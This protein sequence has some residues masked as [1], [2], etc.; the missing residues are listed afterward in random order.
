MT[1]WQDFFNDKSV[2][3]VAKLFVSQ[4]YQPFFDK[5]L[6]DFCR[7]SALAHGYSGHIYEF[8]P[9]GAKSIF[10]SGT[11]YPWGLAFNL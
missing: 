10:A 11:F 4:L 2:G 1:G 9:G 3:I 5:L 6:N 7:T 8:T